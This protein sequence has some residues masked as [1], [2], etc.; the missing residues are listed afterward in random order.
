MKYRW[1]KKYPG[2]RPWQQSLLIEI[3]H[4]GD[5][6]GLSVTSQSEEDEN[7]KQIPE[8]D[9]NGETASPGDK[10]DDR[11]VTE[12][13]KESAGE[14]RPQTV[15]SDEENDSVA[16]ES[17]NLDEKDNQVKKADEA[18]GNAEERCSDY[19]G[20]GIDVSGVEETLKRAKSMLADGDAAEALDLV[21]R[22]GETLSLLEG[23]YNTLANGIENLKNRMD[24]LFADREKASHLTQAVD[25]C[26]DAL[27]NGEY[28]RTGEYI[29][30]AERTIDAWVAHRDRKRYLGAFLG[31][32]GAVRVRFPPGK[33]PS[34]ISKELTEASEQIYSNDLEDIAN[35]AQRLVKMSRDEYLSQRTDRIL[36]VLKGA[37]N[38]L[39]DVDEG[40]TIKADLTGLLTEAAMAMEYKDLPRAAGLARGLE[41]ELSHFDRERSSQQ[42]VGSLVD[43][44]RSIIGASQRGLPKNIGLELMK[45]P[46]AHFQ[47]GDFLETVSMV[48]DA[49]K[50]L[51]GSLNDHLSQEVKKMLSE[52]LNMLDTGTSRG[53]FMDEG[54]GLVSLAQAA[55]DDGEIHQAHRLA[56]L[57]KENIEDSIFSS[58]QEEAIMCLR[59]AD[60]DHSRAIHEGLDPGKTTKLL[61]E[62]RYALKQ[63]QFSMVVK[64]TGQLKS[65]LE[66]A[67]GDHRLTMAREA[68]KAA[69]E[70]VEDTRKAGAKVD[71]LDKILSKANE[72]LENN[73]VTARNLEDIIKLTRDVT[74]RGR[75]LRRNLLRDLAA[76][77]ILEASGEYD[78]ITRA[79]LD[80]SWIASNL[81]R[82][83]TAFENRSYRS[84]SRDAQ[85]TLQMSKTL[86]N[87]HHRRQ[88]L[89]KI[90][91]LHHA[92]NQA[93]RVLDDISG[94]ID[95]L[96]KA[97]AAL[98]ADRYAEASSIA[99]TTSKSVASAMK[100]MRLGYCDGAISGAKSSITKARSVGAD[101]GIAQGLIHRALMCKKENYLEQAREYAELA[102]R[103]ADKAEDCHRRSRYDGAMKDLDKYLATLGSTSRVDLSE[104]HKLIAKATSAADGGDFLTGEKIIL[105]A[106]NTAKELN[107]SQHQ[108]DALD[109]I[110]EANA[111]I[112]DAGG[113]GVST[114]TAQELLKT[115]RK[116]FKSNNWDQAMATA[117]Q[118]ILVAGRLTEEFRR[119]KAGS[120]LGKIRTLLGEMEK[121]GVP[122]YEIQSR[123]AVAN[124]AFKEGDF[125]EAI[126]ISEA[127]LE[128]GNTDRKDW[129][130]RISLNKVLD[131]WR[132]VA[133]V[134]I[135]LNGSTSDTV[136]RSYMD[137]V[138]SIFKRKYLNGEKQADKVGKDALAAVDQWET[139][140]AETRIAEAEKLLSN[141]TKTGADMTAA[142]TIME[143]AKAAHKE[144]NNMDAVL[145][146]NE[147]SRLSED[148]IESFL[149]KKA[150]DAADAALRAVGEC[151]E[152]G[153]DTSV[154][155]G[156]L[157][158]AGKR[159][160]KGDLV[161]ARK[162]YMGIIP[163]VESIRFHEEKRLTQSEFIHME[164]ELKDAIKR[165]LD[166]NEAKTDLGLANKL[167]GDGR[168][169]EVLDALGRVGEKLRSARAAKDTTDAQR[170][171]GELEGELASLNIF[172]NQHDGD[173]D[174]NAEDGEG[175]I[176]TGGHG[177]FQ[178][179]SLK[180]LAE[181]EFQR[182]N[183]K[184]TVRFVESAREDLSRFREMELAMKAHE[185]YYSI[186]AKYFLSDESDGNLSQEAFASLEGAME[187]SNHS[188]V[189]EEGKELLNALKQKHLGKLKK[190]FSG[191]IDNLRDELKGLDDRG[192]D[193]HSAKMIIERA[194]Q[195]LK[196]SYPYLASSLAVEGR[197]LL[198]LASSELKV[199]KLAESMVEAYDQGGEEYF[200]SGNI[201][202][203]IDAYVNGQW[204][205]IDGL[206][207]RLQTTRSG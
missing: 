69:T 15:Q 70:S 144:S 193:V 27:N 102:A 137:A 100:K 195:A 38:A 185:V 163:K 12:K 115:A 48:E 181:K 153:W 101:T 85:K 19:R 64:K 206:I 184:Q 192:G 159:E 20:R 119:K 88:A 104:V 71:M 36:Q 41:Q 194:D 171:L 179:Y 55:V 116:S 51:E 190:R 65:S 61:E 191:E 37:R 162:I 79:G 127:A 45:K 97:E 196:S 28:E 126:E 42:A 23:H 50:A 152:R 14:E 150:K 105:K 95:E 189:V 182:G 180:T 10:E 167:L 16:W 32:V 143:K 53:I 207:Q 4:A 120:N 54:R 134:R 24:N 6:G 68:I 183:Y 169:D 76:D 155:D 5:I 58:Q 113:E 56:K 49:K 197:E 98:N 77:A 122:C 173:T 87:H 178:A 118:S 94:H 2:Y 111:I 26:Q 91:D 74:L 25:R 149:S 43:L 84:A 59:E 17:E 174:K 125:L 175:F 148:I 73:V 29:A 132:T 139:A 52:C 117:E 147:A 106:V 83:K 157:L 8:G 107:S 176:T 34:I 108:K 44:Q 92:L 3:A 89:G 205:K 188:K 133:T 90:F 57:A 186:Q 202:K 18:L 141:G 128:A 151:R 158:E 136:D 75:E 156:S 1:R 13:D 166:V 30:E 63:N 204:E 170:A 140:E 164:R 72:P 47:A 154:L 109:R 33:E 165:K 81:Q 146:S 187:K 67:R 86:L 40:T 172:S 31:A 22:A 9:P 142:L 93:N 80:D 121:T 78:R 145:L 39:E 203:A 103:V 200:G 21:E 201:R 199:K 168:Y 124:R 130:I 131:Q 138:N 177:P 46:L 112:A 123:L 161:G 135:R 160:R 114:D 129:R 82:A 99:D 110:S 62:A 198:S 96:K 35:S 66:K 60:L 7:V 11:T